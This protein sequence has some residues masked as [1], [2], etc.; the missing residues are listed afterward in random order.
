M[1]ASAVCVR[2]GRPRWVPTVGLDARVNP[3]NPAAAAAD[4]RGAEERTRVE[5]VEGARRAWR[6]SARTAQRTLHTDAM[7]ASGRCEVE[8]GWQ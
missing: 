7:V 1:D 6:R 5:G 3:L 8:R 4:A 2:G